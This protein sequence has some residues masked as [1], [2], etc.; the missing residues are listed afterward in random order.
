MSWRLTRFGPS[1]WTE[2]K[3]RGAIFFSMKLVIVPIRTE[4]KSLYLRKRRQL[5]LREKVLTSAWAWTGGFG[6]GRRFLWGLAGGWRGLELLPV[7]SLLAGDA[8]RPPRLSVLKEPS[9]DF[10]NTNPKTPCFACCLRLS[11]CLCSAIMSWVLRADPSV[12]PCFAYR[13]TSWRW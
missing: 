5:K 13:V 2:T 6:A 10:L 8:L 3:R 7:S 4:K 11:S 9:L 12:L 1:W